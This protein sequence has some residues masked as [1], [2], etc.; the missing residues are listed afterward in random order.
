MS[1]TAGK[2]VRQGCIELI[3]GEKLNPFVTEGAMEFALH[4]NQVDSSSLQK[5]R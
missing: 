5:R 1:T 2:Y 3:M 4:P